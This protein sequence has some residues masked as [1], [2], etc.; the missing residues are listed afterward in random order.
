MPAGAPG[1]EQG[2]GDAMIGTGERSAVAAR[3]RRAL[4]V[5]FPDRQIMVRTGGRLVCYSVGRRTQIALASFVLLAAGWTTFTS[6]GHVLHNRIVAAKDAEIAEANLAYRSLLNEVVAYQRRFTEI[7]RDLEANHGMML[8]LVERNAA[9]QQDL[10]SVRGQLET[11]KREREDLLAAREGLK[12]QLGEIE[13]EMDGLANR[14]FSLKGDLASAAADLET[15]LFQRNTAE[16]ERLRAERRI[17]S[18]Q[19][20]LAELQES[21]HAAIRILK[22]RTEQQI[23]VVERVVERTGLGADAL[24]AAAGVPPRG[25]GGPFVPAKANGEAGGRLAA[26]LAAL[27]ARIEHW[28]SVHEMVRRLPLGSPL[29]SYEVTSRFGKRRDPITRK[30]AM[31]YGLDLGGRRKATVYATA[32]GTV[33]QAGWKGR[34]GRFIEIDHGAGLKTRFGHLDKILV[35]RGQEVEFRDRIGL[36]GN[37]GR[38]TGSH[39]HYEIVFKGTAYDPSKFITAGWHVFQE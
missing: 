24:L 39:L 2:D 37:S 22:D 17:E 6:V 11:S 14:N 27:D 4:D 30:W 34:Y 3:L 38:S 12:R 19:D 29:D 35:K 13:S 36:L 15:A 10:L 21:E 1:G 9:L 7:T 20:R 5:L 25:Q 23:A 28:Q 18:L 16:T 33:A 31:H 8:G 32:P 26:E